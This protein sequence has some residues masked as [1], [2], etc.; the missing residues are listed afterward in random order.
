MQPNILN[1]ENTIF[2]NVK[3]KQKM[4]IFSSLF[5]L[6]NKRFYICKHK[7]RYFF[8]ILAR[9]VITFT[10]MRKKKQI[11]LNLK[12]SAIISS[13]SNKSTPPTL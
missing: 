1:E 4:H 6:E 2:F 13:S 5:N 10:E 7:I 3:C 8:V 11:E 9:A 12:K